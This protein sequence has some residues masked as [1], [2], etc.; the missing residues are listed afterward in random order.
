MSKVKYQK[1]KSIIN[2]YVGLDVHD[3]I[4]GNGSFRFPVYVLDKYKEV[5]IEE[6][7]L[8]VRA[9]NCLKRAG[10]KSIYDLMTKITGRA[11]LDRI[12]GCGVDTSRLIMEELFV[13]Q[14]SQL[15]PEHIEG[16]MD[17]LVEM[18]KDR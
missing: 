16:Y 6:L 17:K 1:V 8:T 15:R 13:F 11:D 7:D 9:K 2:Q 5:D 10:I 4:K 3:R 12:R 18:N 14:Y